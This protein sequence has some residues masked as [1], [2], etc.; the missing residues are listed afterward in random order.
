M[1]VF[2]LIVVLSLVLSAGSQ[3]VAQAAGAPQRNAPVQPG[4]NAPNLRILSP[5][6]GQKITTSFVK[7]QYEVTNPAASANTLPVFKL[8][9]DT[10]TPITT[11][12]AEHTFTGLTPGKHVVAVELVDA[13]GTPVQGT[14]AVV[15]FAVL[16]SATNA[17][18][19]PSSEN[20]SAPPS[21]G[22]ASFSDAEQTSPGGSVE[23]KEAPTA[24]E[25]VHSSN[26]L[27]LLSVV[28]FG[29]L[30][31]GLVSSLRTR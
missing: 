26:A 14:Q 25:G 30:V 31:G 28:G 6:P 27:P 18:P 21:T 2:R 24:A 8:R 10:E 11:S 4:A 16:P 20:Q 19:G 22:T 29:V 5:I 1:L 15:H 13:N 17:P 23:T 9:L 12:A 3:L 7:V